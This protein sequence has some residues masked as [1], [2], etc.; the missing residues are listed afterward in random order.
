MIQVTDLQGKTRYVNA[1]M[2]QYVESNPETQ[3][4]L[5]TGVRI[6]A[7]EEPEVIAERVIEYKQRCSQP[8]HPMLRLAEGDEPQESPPGPGVSGCSQVM[9]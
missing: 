1:D 5:A 2:I 7:Q 8:L 4:V 9:G 6:Y 3:I